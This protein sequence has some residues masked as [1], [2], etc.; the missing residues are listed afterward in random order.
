MSAPSGIRSGVGFRNAVLFALN[1]AGLPAATASTPYEGVR[2]TGNKVL[3]ITEPE[4]RRIPY[5][6][7]DGIFGLDVLPP[8]EILTAE[9][10]TGKVNDELDALVGGIKKFTV[11]EMALL[12]INTDK[13]GYE[14][15][16]GMIAYRQAQDTDPESA[17]FGARSWEFRVFPKV[18]IISRESGFADTPDERVYTLVPAYVT[19]HLWGAAFTEAAEGFTRSQMIRGNAWGKPKIV[20]WL[21]DATE[22]EFLFPTDAQASAAA[23]VAVFVNG[24]IQTTGITVATT[25]V[26]FT[27][28]PAAAAV[29]VAVYETN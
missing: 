7:D 28:P 8:N 20:A 19:S 12:G 9:L 26:T 22:D 16:V 13:K 4:P 17:T 6:G 18:Q 14:P 23:K 11:G 27:A 25:G 10:H 3:T 21:G 2:I 24:T 15:Q 1:A 29:I 5:T